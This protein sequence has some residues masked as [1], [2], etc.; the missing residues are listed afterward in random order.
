MGTKSTIEWTE[1]TAIVDRGG[2]RVRF[3]QR[4][5]L[6]GPGTQL[7]RRMRL[8]DLK[9]CRRCAE[10]L[11]SASVTKN[12]LCRPHENEDYRNRYAAGAKNAIAQRVHARKRRTKP[13]PLIAQEY[14]LEKFEGRCAYCSKEATT[15]D[16]IIPI[17]KG[18]ETEPGNIVPACA[19]CNS[20]KKDRDVDEWI[21]GRVV[22]PLFVDIL[23]LQEV[24]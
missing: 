9:W 3:Y 2:R 5:K 4:K 24:L 20:S 8:S 19:S 12:G 21:R 14:L 22:N 6:V 18:G 17:T 11:P 13:V 23:I 7:R 16:H 15:W 10:W 1:M